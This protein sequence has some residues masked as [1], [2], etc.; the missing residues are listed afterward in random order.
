MQES[1]SYTLDSEEDVLGTLILD[2]EDLQP[3]KSLGEQ[4]SKQ[5]RRRQ[6]QNES[7]R[8]NMENDWLFSSE[9][10]LQQT[11]QEV[12][13]EIADTVVEDKDREHEDSDGDNSDD[14]DILDV[15]DLSATHCGAGE[16]GDGRQRTL[17]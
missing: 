15:S 17:K 12:M 9:G 16:E 1:E 13:F 2:E 4:N 5:G 10:D 3:M 14:C 8:Q 11:L 6:V 7:Y